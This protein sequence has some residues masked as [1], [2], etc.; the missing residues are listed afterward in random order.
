VHKNDGS[1]NCTTLK[2]KTRQKRA[3]TEV[4]VFLVHEHL[5]DILMP[6]PICS[7]LRALYKYS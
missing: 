1:R 2:Q 5:L 6:A 3:T 7:S 4:I